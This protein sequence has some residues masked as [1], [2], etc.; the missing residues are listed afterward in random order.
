[1]TAKIQLWA[2]SIKGKES[3]K[4]KSLICSWCFEDAVIYSD[5]GDEMQSIIFKF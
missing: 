1:M 2:L 3:L 4:I 5:K